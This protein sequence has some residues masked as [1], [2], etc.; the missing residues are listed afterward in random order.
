MVRK[1]LGQFQGFT[2]FV[3]KEKLIGGYPIKKRPQ[4]TFDRVGLDRP[5]LSEV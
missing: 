3:K 4:T 5:R 1:V 2:E